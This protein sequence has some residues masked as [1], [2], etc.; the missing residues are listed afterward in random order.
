MRD[1]GKRRR[2]VCGLVLLGGVFLA[3]VWL[4]AG[5]TVSSEQTVGRRWIPTQVPAGSRFVGSAACAECHGQISAVYAHNP[6]G[7]ALEAVGEAPILRDNP[8]LGFTEGRYRFEIR[9]EGDRSIYT[10]TSGK[11]MI[12]EP[13]LYSF[14]QGQAG[15]TYLLRRG[16]DYYESRV[17]FYRDIRGL[18]LT[19]G[20]RGSSPASIEEAFGRRLS[21]DEVGQCFSCH[22]TNAVSNSQLHLDKMLPGVTCESCH[23]PGGEHVVAGRAGR[24]NGELI[25]N[26]G[27]LGGDEI[28][29][30]FCGSCHRG[31]EKV[32]TRSGADGQFNVR[33]Q[34]YR[35]FNSACYSDDRRISCIGCHSPHESVNKD[36]GYY[37]GRCISCHQSRPSNGGGA[38]VGRVCRTGKRDCASCHMPKVDLPGAH[39]RFTD[40]R[41]RIVRPGDPYPN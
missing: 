6:M 24:P 30:E 33:F 25:F 40:H 15:Q 26:A 2:V 38:S 1:R 8:R 12:S 13:I 19:I 16:D 31:V 21:R 7:S 34:P 36:A 14:G 35:I 11:E 20:Y 37:D 5:R 3:G 18:D 32:T 41:I 39:F 23:G 29:Q 4:A 28:N 27:R 17:S 10:V 22:A 9:R